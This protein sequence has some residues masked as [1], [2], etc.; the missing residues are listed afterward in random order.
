M[1]RNHEF[2]QVTTIKFHLQVRLGEHHF[3]TTEGYEQD[4]AIA[5]VTIHR[6]YGVATRYDRDIAVIKLASPARINDR[7][8]PVC[9]QSNNAVFPPGKYGGP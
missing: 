3:E 7:V 2:K 8:A 4:I 5:S 1:S 6:S 9:L